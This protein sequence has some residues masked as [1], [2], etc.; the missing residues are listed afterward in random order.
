M[1][2]PLPPPARDVRE[3]LDHIREYGLCIIEGVLSGATLERARTA[4]YR[5]AK[6]ILRVCLGILGIRIR[7][8]G[9][10]NIQM[11]RAAVYAFNHSSNM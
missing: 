3:G 2:E 4:L 8:H 5:A 1:S 7:L 10:E 6:I 11:N 9:A